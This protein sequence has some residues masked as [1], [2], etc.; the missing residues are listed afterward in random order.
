[1]HDL[2]GIKMKSLTIYHVTTSMPSW[3]GVRGVAKEAFERMDVQLDPPMHTAGVLEGSSLT[4]YQ[5]EYQCVIQTLS[6]GLEAGLIH[7]DL[8][9]KESRYLHLEDCIVV[10]EAG[11]GNCLQRDHLSSGHTGCNCFVQ[12]F[13]ECFYS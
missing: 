6:D 10:P 3:L 8:L 13:R 5:Q 1:M 7:G 9:Y 11:L 12:F 2:R 4:D